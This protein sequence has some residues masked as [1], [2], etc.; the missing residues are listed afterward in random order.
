L[1]DH[2][3]KSA[4]RNWR[5]KCVCDTT[6]K[7]LNYGQ[8]LT[9]AVALAD[10]L[11]PLTAAQ[12]K[13][14]VLLPPSVAATL[15]D[16]AVA[17]LHKTAVNL[18]YVTSP[19]ARELAIEQCGIKQI[20][21]SRAFIQKFP[22]LASMS[23]LVF[24]EDLAGEIGARTKATAYLKARFLPRRLLAKAR[25][26]DPDDLATVVFTSGT[27]GRAKGVMLS[28][29][30]ILSNIQALLMVFRIRPD[31]DVCAVLPFFHCF[32]YTLTIWL[33][34][35]AGA[36]ASYVPNP[37]DGKTVGRMVR[38]NKC[39]LLFATPTFLLAYVRQAQSH[40]FST[41]RFVIAGAE[42]LKQSIVDSFEDT[43]G[44]RPLEGYGTTEL[45]PVVSLN[46]PDVKLGGV[47]QLA[48]KTGTVGQPLPGV[49]VKIVDTDTGGQLDLG[50]SGLVL[51]KGPNV[52]LGYLDM[53]EQTAA[54]LTDGWYN[55]GD[56]GHLDRDGFLTITGR[57][58]RFSKIGGEMVPH[59]GIEQVY[60]DALGTS[61]Q[62]VAVTSIQSA[63]RGEELVVLYLDQAGE[64]DMLHKIITKSPVPNMWKPR[65]HN[66]FKV[67]ALPLLGSGKLDVMALRE[68]ASAAKQNAKWHPFSRSK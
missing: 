43:F 28:H 9:A 15:A 18:N 23:G 65:R 64:P 47:H 54:V 35:I 14:G 52:M 2:V 36:S 44:T 21:S 57:V 34:V 40:D 29:H 33:P 42:K 53:Q 31:D 68:I 1:I 5:K 20:I 58:S 11:G 26:F 12:D 60:H 6:G 39:T 38:D 49:A 22:H 30:N 62:L 59:I 16:F 61:E 19:H 41:L 56:I 45:S 17:L 48:N 8:T 10:K 51:V 32:G 37:L 46:L 7:R 66:Y 3:I 13:V 24:I 63:R 27:S 50:Q 55:T 67:D 4:R 25:R